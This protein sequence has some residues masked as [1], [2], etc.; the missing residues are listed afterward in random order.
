[1]SISFREENRQKLEPIVASI[2]ESLG[3][4]VGIDDEND[5]VCNMDFAMI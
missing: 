3:T 4:I 1:M 5:A 2:A